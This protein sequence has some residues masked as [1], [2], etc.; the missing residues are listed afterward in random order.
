MASEPDYGPSLRF[1]HKT[2]EMNSENNMLKEFSGVRSD[3]SHLNKMDDSGEM[4]VMSKPRI[5]ALLGLY[6]KRDGKSEDTKA[7]QGIDKKEYQ[8]VIRFTSSD[9]VHD[10][11]SIMEPNLIQLLPPMAI[12][13]YSMC[14]N[15]LFFLIGNLM[16]SQSS[17]H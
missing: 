16:Y 5:R 4:S 2:L 10:F 12:H 13:I 17:I 1:Y 15:L 14:E 7:S 3:S 6:D 9:A 8:L 11:C